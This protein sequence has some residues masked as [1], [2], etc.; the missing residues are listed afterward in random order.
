[1]SRSWIALGIVL[2]AAGLAWWQREA[3]TAALPASVTSAIGAARSQLPAA[4]TAPAGGVAP[5]RCSGADGRVEYTNAACP[6]GTREQPLSG[7]SVSV[8]PAAPAAAAPPASA[9]SRSLLRQ[10]APDADGPTI[11]ERMADRLP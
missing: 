4:V 9:A 3:L 5:R 7:G 8:L 11:K 6:P 1:M 10:L 2:L